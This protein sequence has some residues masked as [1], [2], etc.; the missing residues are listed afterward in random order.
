MVA[1]LLQFDHGTAVETSLPALFLGNLDEFRGGGIFGTFF[2]Q[3]VVFA[4][5]ESADLGVAVLAFAVFA[6]GVNRILVDVRWFDP[7]AT[8]AGGTV[9]AVFGGIFLVLLVPLSFEFVVKEPFDMSE[10]D[11]FGIATFRRHVSGIGHGEGEETFQ[12]V[13]THPVS[14]G[15]LRSLV[16]W[17]VI[18][19]T[20]KALDSAGLPW[21][22]ATHER[23]E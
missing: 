4:I 13:A 15:K 3:R 21:L 17:N 6:A 19:A 11:V 5:A 16:R 12:A 1:T 8:G 18:V 9:D 2:F 23:Q 10:R 7:V 22:A 20:S 14:T